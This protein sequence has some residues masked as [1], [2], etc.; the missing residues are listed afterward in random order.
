MSHSITRDSRPSTWLQVWRSANRGLNGIDGTLGTFIGEQLA[1]G[2]GGLLLLGDLAALH[3]LPALT[4]AHRLHGCAIVVLNNNGGGIF[5]HLA[6]AQVAGY[7]PLIRTPHGLTFAHAAA[8]F[9]LDYQLATGFAELATALDSAAHGSGCL[10]IECALT[11][12]DAV[13]Q[14]RRLL[15]VAAG[16]G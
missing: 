4:A 2:G 3:D 14:H 8:Q 6:V 15:R 10:L 12:L 16:N 1:G 5:D 9:G 11:G 7:E 13:A